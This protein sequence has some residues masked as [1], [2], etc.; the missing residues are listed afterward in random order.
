MAAAGAALL[1]FVHDP[2]AAVQAAARNN[3]GTPREK[4]P[5]FRVFRDG[6]GEKSRFSRG[7][8]PRR[9]A[10]SRQMRL[11][12]RQSVEITRNFTS[13]PVS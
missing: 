12:C 9:V 6:Q 13:L 8:L 4:R 10:F 1:C 5:E 2:P 7:F 3:G 11:I